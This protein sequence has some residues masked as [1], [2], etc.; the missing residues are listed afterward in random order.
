HR[1]LFIDPLPDLVS[2]TTLPGRVCRSTHATAASQGVSREA[3]E[4]MWDRYFPAVET[5]APSSEPFDDRHVRRAAALAHGLQAEAPA[6]ALEFA[7][8]RREKLGA[9]GPERVAE[10]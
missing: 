10:R 2:A 1:V 5:I 6:A 3:A 4:S 9:G 8:H 7:E